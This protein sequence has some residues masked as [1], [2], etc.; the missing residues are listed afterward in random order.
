[1]LND[2][3]ER[4]GDY[5]FDR[6]RALLGTAPPP[7]GTAP[8]LLHL[9]EPKHPPPEII[10]AAVDSAA[11]G[12]GRYPPMVGTPEFRAAVADWLTRRYRLPAAMIEPDRHV[13]PVAGTREA[14]FLVALAA[15]PEAKA[16]QR[17]VVLMPNPFYQV[18]AGA[19]VLCGAEPVYVAAGKET[20]F[21][22]DFAALDDAVLARAALAYYCSPAN[23][24]GAVA[25]LDRLTAVVALARR[26][27][28]VVA[29][30]ECYSEIYDRAPPPGGL[31]ACAAAGGAMDNVLVFQ[32]LSK[33]SSA[34]G[35]RSGFVAGHADL[36]R[37]F[38]RLREYGGAAQPLPVLA[39]SAALWR[40]EA[41]VEANR[42][43][44]RHKFDLAEAALA[45]RLG[46]Y[47]PQGGF[48][49]WLDVGDG[50]AA[51][52]RLWT[53]AGVRVLPGAYLAA[54]DATGRNP[55]APYIRLALVDDAA[56]TA[57]A[58]DRIARTL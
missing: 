14:L 36:I 24:Q 5:P 19:A 32:S 42:T 43:L 39:A 28:F 54:T 44:Y 17:P 22:P 50:E 47:R 12:W 40:D 57:V 9:G 41:H 48:Y 3:L 18:Y 37:R 23:P 29:F 15:I 53:E 49:L 55:G 4:I 58:L 33:R 34:P 20:G 8:I 16:G 27:D 7:D 31:E 13:L 26:H 6:L 10:R 45:G 56:T 46:F 2:R 35:L 38:T 11:A 30:D 25:G 51:A 1:M 52:R 21:L